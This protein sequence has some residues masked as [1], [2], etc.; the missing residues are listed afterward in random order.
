MLIPTIPR[1]GIVTELCDSPFNA[2]TDQKRHFASLEALKV[3]WK[4]TF[5]IVQQQRVVKSI[6]LFF[7]TGWSIASLAC[8]LAGLIFAYYLQYAAT[9]SWWLCSI[10]TKDA[11]FVPVRPLTVRDIFFNS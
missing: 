8:F 4:D 3:G 5:H 2:Q 9:I 11:A 10:D 6:S 7:S 1:L